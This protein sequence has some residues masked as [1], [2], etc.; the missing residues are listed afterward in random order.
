MMTI[1]DAGAPPRGK[2]KG[3]PTVPQWCKDWFGTFPNTWP[4]SERCTF[5]NVDGNCIAGDSCRFAH[6]CFIDGMHDHGAAWPGYHNGT[7]QP[8]A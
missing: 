1:A 5:W 2:G 4:T 8:Y 7:E 6:D 3:K